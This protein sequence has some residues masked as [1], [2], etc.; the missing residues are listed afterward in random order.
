MKKSGIKK[1]K[2]LEFFKPD[3]STKIKRPFYIS[4]VSAG[5]PSPAE[6]YMEKELDLNEHLIR[7]PAATFFVRVS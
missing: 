1:S 2:E 5:F 3:T 6:D 7:H 4:S